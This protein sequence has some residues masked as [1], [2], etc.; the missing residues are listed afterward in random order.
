MRDEQPDRFAA[1]SPTVHI[2][3][4]LYESDRAN[5]DHITGGDAA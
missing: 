1:L 5:H 2:A 3:V 4:G